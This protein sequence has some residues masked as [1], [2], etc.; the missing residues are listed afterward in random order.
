MIKRWWIAILTGLCA[1]FASVGLMACGGVGESSENS[2]NCK[3]ELSRDESYYIVTEV[4]DDDCTELIIPSEYKGKPVKEIGH[5]AFY[6]CDSLTSVII[7]D[8]VTSIGPAAFYKCKNLTEIT[9]PDSVTSIGNN[10]FYFCRSLTSVEIPDSVTSIGSYAFRYCSNLTSVVIPD[11]VTSIGSYAFVSCDS[12]TEI[13]FEDTS[14]WYR[15]YN[16]MN[17]ENKTNGT[18]VSLI[19]PSTNVTYFKTTYESD[20]WYK[21]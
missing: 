10:A 11:S 20:Y 2:E 17:W 3:M 8:S 16:S 4:E 6:D 14:T 7:P 18:V 15:V 19:N 13:I 21:L 5:S 1:C 9:I 12:L